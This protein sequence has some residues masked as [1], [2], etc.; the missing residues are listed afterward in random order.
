MHAR[1]VYHDATLKLKH[2]LLTAETCPEPIEVGWG[3]IRRVV[4]LCRTPV[5]LTLGA[6]GH[7]PSRYIVSLL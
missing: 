1:A 2:Q 5:W 4:W 6:R 7:L 3:A